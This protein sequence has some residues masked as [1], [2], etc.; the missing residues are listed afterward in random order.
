LAST[1]LSLPPR[2]IFFDIAIGRRQEQDQLRSSIGHSNGRHDG[3]KVAAALR[4]S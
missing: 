4:I 1:T 3:G 2:A